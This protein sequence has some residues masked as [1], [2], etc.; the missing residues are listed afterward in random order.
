MTVQ[1]Q[2]TLEIY[3]TEQD[4]TVR[5][6]PVYRDCA[7]LDVTSLRSIDDREAFA[8]L[9]W[10]IEQSLVPKGSTVIERRVI[11]AGGVTVHEPTGGEGTA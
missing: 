5:Y 7:E 11:E 10:I 9:A 2:L 6:K 8:T 3:D 1:Y 4:E